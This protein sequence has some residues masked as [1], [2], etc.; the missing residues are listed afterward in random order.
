MNAIIIIIKQGKTKLKTCINRWRTVRDDCVGDKY[1]SVFGGFVVSV[2][3]KASVWTESEL[4][5]SSNGMALIA[6]SQEALLTTPKGIQLRHF[7][8]CSA[9][10]III[11]LSVFCSS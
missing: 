3:L 6:C 5:N 8:C 2:S 11:T 7:T 1:C 10:Q 4:G 9:Q